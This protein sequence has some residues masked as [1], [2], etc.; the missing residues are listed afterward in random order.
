MAKL[1]ITSRGSVWQYRFEVAPIDGKRKQVSKSGFKT[2]KEAEI[3]GTKAMA[4]HNQSGQTFTPAT[5]SVADYLDFWM[6]SCVKMNLK[7]NTQQAYRNIVDKHLKPN[8]GHYRLQSLQAATIQE[9]TNGLKIKGLS[10]SHTV[11]IVT[12]LSGAL[13]YAVEPLHYIQFNPCDYIKYPKFNENK[14]EKRYIIDLETFD[15]ITDRFKEPSPFY[16]PLMIG[17]HTGLRVGEIFGLTWEN[18]D[19]DSRTLTVEKISLKRKCGGNE[20]SLCFGSPKTR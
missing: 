3:A 16:L 7:Y 12:T 17:F 5:I 9:Y 6:D 14:K 8:L 15:K 10:R 11:G 19:L 2:K 1:N 18:I 4:E 20:S 13:R